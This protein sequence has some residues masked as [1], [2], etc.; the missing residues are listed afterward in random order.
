MGS[1]SSHPTAVMS[2]TL[3]GVWRAQV[4][5][6]HAEWVSCLCQA[7]GRLGLGVCKV[8][9][10]ST[11][12][13]LGSAVVSQDWCPCR[14]PEALELVLPVVLL[15]DARV[16][17][18]SIRTPVVS[19]STCSSFFNNAIVLDGNHRWVPGLWC[20]ILSFLLKPSSICHNGPKRPPKSHPAEH[21]KDQRGV[22]GL[23]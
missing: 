20:Y 17:P 7:E 2:V 8:S 14:V 19:I 4:G 12:A 11:W 16:A 13:L 18:D 10:R 9:N 15:A 1:Q 3:S 23:A 22:E 6:Y 5:P 21:S